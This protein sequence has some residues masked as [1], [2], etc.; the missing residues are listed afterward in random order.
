MDNLSRSESVI[1]TSGDWDLWL[2]EA[3]L[4]NEPVPSCCVSN[5]RSV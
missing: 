2:A 4:E 5:R 1:I 3:Q